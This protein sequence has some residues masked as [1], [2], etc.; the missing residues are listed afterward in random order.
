[1]ENEHKTRI[2]Q[3]TAIF[4]SF[5]VLGFFSL[6]SSNS[7][8]QS[9]QIEPKQRFYLSIYSSLQT[10]FKVWGGCSLRV[11]VIHC[12]PSV[13]LLSLSAGVIISSAV[14]LAGM[15]F[16]CR[17]LRKCI[18]FQC[19]LC[20]VCDHQGSECCDAF[21]KWC[22]NKFPRRHEVKLNPCWEFFWC[23]HF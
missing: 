16:S 3:I 11:W 19:M 23:L 22:G 8:C 4:V 18:N 2:L 10:D 9:L 1:M 13:F 7:N 14:T 17:S 20:I 5:L 6:K 12:S 21:S 15:W